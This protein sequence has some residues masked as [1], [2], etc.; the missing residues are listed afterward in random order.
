MQ[1]RVEVSVDQGW[2]IPEDSL[3]RV[4]SSSFLSAKTIDIRSGEAELVLPVGGVIPSAPPTDIFSAVSA[5]AAEFS[6]LNREQITPLLKTLNSLASKVEGDTPRITQQLVRFTERLNG[7]LT[8]LE[9]ILWDENIEAIDRTILHVD[10]TA[11]SFASVG[12]TLTKTARRIDNLA[13]N[14]D[15]LIEANADNVDQSLK[16]L[17]YTLAAISQTID[18]VVH[19]LDGTARNMNEFSRLIRQNPGLLLDGTPREAVSPARVSER[20]AA[21]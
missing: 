14:V 17:Q 20:P 11:K 2:R 21:Q 16:D 9:Q 4:G 8:P 5:T 19:N 18:S 12:G 15:R 3:A 10:E 6:D 1:F 13:A 7:A